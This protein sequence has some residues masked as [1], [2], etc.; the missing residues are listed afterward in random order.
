MT[1]E[2]VRRLDRVL[3]EFESCR[4]VSANALAAIRLLLLTGCRKGEI[5]NLRWDFMYGPFSTA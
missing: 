2:E 3:D 4:G 1:D 5:L